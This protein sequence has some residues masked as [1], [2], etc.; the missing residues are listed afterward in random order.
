MK[1]RSSNIFILRGHPNGNLVARMSI[2][3]IQAIAFR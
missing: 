3:T 1:L 2:S